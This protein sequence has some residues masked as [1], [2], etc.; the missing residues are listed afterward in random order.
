MVGLS[1][2]FGFGTIGAGCIMGDAGSEGGFLFTCQSS[3][4]SSAKKLSDI[5]ERIKIK[6]DYKIGKR[7]FV[8][9]YLFAFGDDN[10][11]L[12][13]EERMYDG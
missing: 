7:V 5:K 4:S 2:G 11:T 6:I 3:E 10:N 9:S 8:Y 13:E 1:W 12:N